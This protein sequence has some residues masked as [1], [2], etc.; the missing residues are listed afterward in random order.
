MA[1]VDRNI[2]SLFS[3]R[4]C[5]PFPF[6]CWIPFPRVREHLPAQLLLIPDLVLPAGAPGPA[7]QCPGVPGSAASCPQ[8]L[9][10]WVSGTSI[11][12][13]GT[14]ARLRSFKIVL[15][16]LPGT[17]PCFFQAQLGKLARSTESFLQRVWKGR[18]GAGGVGGTGIVPGSPVLLRGSAGAAPNSAAW[19]RGSTQ[20]AAGAM[21]G[22]G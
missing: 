21:L 4:S 6:R 5:L 14:G 8:S 19:D 1:P 13:P 2:F 12:S 17:V 9:C 16:E 20:G 10:H 22:E 3:L 15:D 18:A 7:R 11:S